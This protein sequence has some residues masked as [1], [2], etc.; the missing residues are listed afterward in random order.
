MRARTGTRETTG[1][2]REN[3]AVEDRRGAV[4]DISWQCTLHRQKEFR[5]GHTLPICLSCHTVVFDLSH[6]LCFPLTLVAFSQVVSS[7]L[8]E[9][10]KS[11]LPT[12]P[13]RMPSCN[14]AALFRFGKN[15]PTSRRARNRASLTSPL[16]I[17]ALLYLCCLTFCFNSHSSTTYPAFAITV[18]YDKDDL[19]ET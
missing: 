19:S 3:L 9:R 1:R 15:L 11:Q 6:D 16:Q 13:V 14:S 18:C 4:C 8:F 5:H 7:V 10:C 12:I 2:G 17:P